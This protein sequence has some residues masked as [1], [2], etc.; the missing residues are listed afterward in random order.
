PPSAAHF[1]YTTLFRSSIKIVPD[2]TQCARYGLNTGDIQMVVQAAI[3]GQAVSQ[4]FE[5]EKSFALTVRWLPQYRSD[6][7]ALRRITV[8]SRS[9]EHTSELQSPCN[10]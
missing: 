1:P 4:V 3:G 9:E 10:L 2:R 7:S 8:S 6:L 5:G